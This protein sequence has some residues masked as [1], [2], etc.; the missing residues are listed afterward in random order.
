MMSVNKK[1]FTLV[2]VMI[3]VLI[4]SL[5]FMGIISWIISTTN[6][7]T[8]T[9]QKVMAL[10]LAKEGVEIVYN[11]RNT[12]R[13]RWY[14]QKDACWL[15]ADPLLEWADEATCSWNAWIT[16]WRRSIQRAQKGDNYYYRLAWRKDW[17]VMGN[18]KEL[19]LDLEKF[20]G[21]LTASDLLQPDFKLSL[22]W[23][24]W[25]NDGDAGKDAWHDPMWWE[26]YRYIAVDGLYRKDQNS[27]TKINC[28]KW[29]D[30]P[31]ALGWT[32]CWSWDIAKELR[33]C[34]VVVYTKPKQWRIQICS[35]MTNFEE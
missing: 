25:Y 22:T 20:R 3:V 9:R 14:E 31:L 7:L 17:W 5:T 30:N 18:E 24:R 11:I 26:F 10:N 4:I 13:R 28:T 8:E 23:W 12:N 21:A 29:S 15:N 27:V 35:I 2:E 19:T 16:P 33:F 32:T 34:S 6:Y 1:W